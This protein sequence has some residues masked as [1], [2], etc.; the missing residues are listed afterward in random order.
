MFLVVATLLIC[1]KAIVCL[2]GC[3]VDSL[4]LGNF[5]C[6]T[7]IRE[8]ISVLRCFRW[9]RGLEKHQHPSTN[10]DKSRV[11]SDES[12]VNLQRTSNLQQPNSPSTSQVPPLLK[13]VSCRLLRHKPTPIGA[14]GLELLW[15][16]DVGAWYF[17]SNQASNPNPHAFHGS[18]E[19]SEEP[20]LPR[21]MFSLRQVVNARQ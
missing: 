5:F 4:L 15:C 17:V 19:N 18:T 6:K 13:A 1:Q 11:N 14:W 8:I 16:L 3:C 9:S 2:V 7:N 21:E 20:L 10:S 12:R